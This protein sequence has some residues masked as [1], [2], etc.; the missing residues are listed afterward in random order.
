MFALVGCGGDVGA[1]QKGDAG[2]ETPDASDASSIPDQGVT[3]ADSSM[4]DVVQAPPG[5]FLLA[6]ETPYAPA[7]DGSNWGN[8]TSFSISADYVAA[9]SSPAIPKSTKAPMLVADPIG[10]AFR[11]STAEVFIANRGGNLSGQS[12]I[13]SFPYNKD[14]KT[15]GAGS[16]AI[17]GF[18]GFH[19]MAFTPKEDEIFVGT[20]N[21]GMR[22]FKYDGSKWNEV[23]P[24]LVGGWVRGVQVSPD[25]KRLYATTAHS[26]ILQFDLTTN[27]QL[28]SIQLKDT[29]AALHFMSLCGPAIAT[30]TVGCSPAQL[31]V[32]DS[33]QSGP[34]AIYR[35]DIDKNDDLV[36]ETIIPADATFHTAISPDGQEL[37]SGE[38]AL[39]QIQR[40]KPSSSTWTASGPVIKTTNNIGTILVFPENVIPTPIN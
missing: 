19:Q 24:Q 21:E 40:F 35:F 29:T 37:Y 18:T 6:T 38:S 30:F 8:I 13:S 39:N 1:F 33:L 5:F 28:P 22:R 7:G 3:F 23:L 27:T 14:T 2:N 11:W 12:T 9:T 10:L 31:Y 20:N 15:F 4:P 34:R 25:G 16:L 17:S 36:N 26:D 32:S